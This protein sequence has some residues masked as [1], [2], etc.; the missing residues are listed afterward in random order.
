M[1]RSDKQHRDAPSKDLQSVNINVKWFPDRH[2]D[3][4]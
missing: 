1:K 4:C 3:I 2:T